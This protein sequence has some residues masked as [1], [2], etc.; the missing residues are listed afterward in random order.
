MNNK[1]KSVFKDNKGQ[2]IVELF[3]CFSIILISVLFYYQTVAITVFKLKSL[4]AAYELALTGARY[5][6]KDG[7]LTGGEYGS[8]YQGFKEKWEEDKNIYIDVKVEPPTKEMKPWFEGSG[9]GAVVGNM[10]QMFL[11][12]VSVAMLSI[13]GDIASLAG[14]RG[15]EYARETTAVVSYKVPNFLSFL[16]GEDKYFI[17]SSQAVFIVDPLYTMYPTPNP[18]AGVPWLSWIPWLGEY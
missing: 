15:K 1:L 18:F 5:H 7:L 3:F 8:F 12:F 11:S 16:F 9:A 14:Y 2:A 13:V 6:S 10:V 4:I 17:V